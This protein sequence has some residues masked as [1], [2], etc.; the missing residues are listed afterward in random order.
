MASTVK[1]LIVDDSV[2]ILRTLQ[3]MLESCPDIEVVGTALNGKEAVE[4]T[5][6]LKPDIVTMDI[7][8]PVMNGIDAT[9]IIMEVCPTPILVI[10]T[11]T[12]EG[13]QVT[14]DALTNGA[15]DFVLKNSSYNSAV[16]ATLRDDI[17][18]KILELARNTEFRNVLTRQKL[19]RNNGNHI[20]SAS[21]SGSVADTPSPSLAIRVEHTA[22]MQPTPVQPSL[23]K[24]V[25]DADLLRKRPAKTDAQIA[26]IGVSTGGPLSL[27]KVIPD[28]PAD[29]PMPIII[30]QHMPSKFTASLAN[31][32]DSIARLRVKEAE[33]GELLNAGTVYIAPGGMQMTVTRQKTVHISTEP[34]ASLY[35]PSVDVLAS[36]VHAVY[37]GNVLAVMMTG[38]GRDGADGFKKLSQAGA[39]VIAQNAESCVVYGMPRA[40]IDEGT[41]NDILHLDDIAHAMTDSVQTSAGAYRSTRSTLISSM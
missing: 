14:I 3:K 37:G 24:S 33:D 26:I 5:C 38:M 35:K 18:A 12:T 13:S 28:L 7:E 36:S 6:A 40:V 17:T 10:S 41:A 27:Q 19:L 23:Q 8:M 4:K 20:V 29:F 9:R 32:L 30:V 31:R 25:H 39:Y 22:P 16:L 15:V 21:N 2:F 1:V 11:H 34:R